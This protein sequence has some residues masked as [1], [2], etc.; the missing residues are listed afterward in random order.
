MTYEESAMLWG[1]VAGVLLVGGVVVYRRMFG[2]QT[3][4]HP[5]RRPVTPPPV[6]IPSPL[7]APAAPQIYHA[8]S[9]KS[10]R[11]KRH[12]KK[13]YWGFGL[14]V[15]IVLLV[16]LF[17]W[18]FGGK[19]TPSSS[20]SAVAVVPPPPCIRFQEE[21]VLETSGPKKTHA[22][23]TNGQMIEIFYESTEAGRR[24]RLDYVPDGRVFFDTVGVHRGPGGYGPPSKEKIVFTSLETDPKKTIWVAIRFIN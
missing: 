3:N 10:T 15:S 6:V 20:P 18:L 14:I 16:L 23:V 4:L 5:T 2:P 11:W 1:T 8:S 22:V 17:S 21:F 12:Q 7:P 24:L 19:K 9:G 13:V